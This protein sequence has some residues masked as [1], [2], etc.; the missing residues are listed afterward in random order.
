M[1][2]QRCISPPK[3]HQG[4]YTKI[5]NAMLPAVEIEPHFAKSTFIANPT[6]LGWKPL[7]WK[8]PSI[9]ARLSRFPQGCA[10]TVHFSLEQEIEQ[11]RHLKAS[12]FRSERPEEFR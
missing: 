6:W 8:C 4:W 9:V 11:H 2:A 7:P 10:I 12:R 5:C 3:F 1:T